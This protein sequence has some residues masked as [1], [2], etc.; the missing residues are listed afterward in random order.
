MSFSRIVVCVA[1]TVGLIAILAMWLTRERESTADLVGPTPRAQEAASILELGGVESS[2]SLGAARGERARLVTSKGGTSGSSSSSTDD[3]LP[4]SS[5]EQ[6]EDARAKALAVVQLV[7]EDVASAAGLSD[8]EKESLIDL[9]VEQHI[10]FFGLNADPVTSLEGADEHRQMLARHR[11]EIARLVGSGRAGS[12]MDYQRSIDARL[13][14]EELRRELEL[15]EMP[16]T[17]VQRRGLIKA[18]IEQGA[19]VQTPE[20]SGADSIEAMAQELTARVQQRDQKMLQIARSVLETA[21]MLR[22]EEMLRQ[23][24]DA[25]EGSLRALSRSPE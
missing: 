20:F 21:Q 19:Y 8:V 24:D 7:Y 22:Y 6:E 1:G 5:A 17:D 9:L 4:E 10:E 14:V 11:A 18:A 13:Q 15:A 25:M 12:V 23:R 16:L 2:Q 3:P